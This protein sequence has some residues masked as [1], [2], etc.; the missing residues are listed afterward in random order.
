MN[1]EIREMFS[2]FEH[3]YD[4]CVL[5]LNWEELKFLGSKQ[6]QTCR[7]CQRS[8]PEVTFKKKAHAIPEMLGNRRLLNHYECDSCNQFFSDIENHLG[9]YTS[10]WR[11][12]SQVRGK[13]GTPKYKK[14]LEIQSVDGQLRISDSIDSPSIFNNDENN[15]IILPGIRDPYIPVAVY[16]CFVKMAL[17]LMPES[18]IQHFRKTIEWI[19]E[20]D[21]SKMKCPFGLLTFV[22][23]TPGFKVYPYPCNW[24]F[25]RKETAEPTTP[26]SIYAVCFSSL[27]FQITI[28]HCEC[29][30]NFLAY[31]NK[32][33]QAKIAA[34]PSPYY[35][36]HPLGPSQI[37][38]KDLSGADWVRGE[39]EYISI[40][41]D[42]KEEI[43]SNQRNNPEEP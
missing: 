1:E 19:M 41:Y 42:L 32:G 14:D 3:K 2:F 24:L 20:P 13:R 26:Y 18:E 27:M 9:N 15:E 35:E 30:D 11:A 43:I 22:Q 21:H 38:V 8:R 5:P 12:V 40:S 6:D 4:A 29:D 36:N 37:R 39:K 17:T 34:L 23:F 10:F 28:P 33:G 7:F 16:K 25:L 31:L